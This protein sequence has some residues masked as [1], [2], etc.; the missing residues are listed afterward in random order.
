MRANAC[1]AAIE[2]RDWIDSFNVQHPTRSLVTRIGLHAGE[3]ALGP[4]GGEYHVMGDTPNTAS[5]IQALNKPLATT[6]L[7]SVV[8][9]RDV[10]DLCLRPLGSF[11]LRGKSGQLGVAE[12]MGQGESV[13]RMTRE[14]RRRFAK[15]LQSFKI[16][17][18]SES[19]RLFQDI[20]SDYP[21]DG[22]ARYFREMCERLAGEE[23]SGSS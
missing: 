19:L 14:L 21:S 6:L 23:L 11:A 15:A 18:W 3:I 1:R 10:E 16:G 12:I 17:Y 2:I 7:A 5:R 9:V 22:P 20:L 4:V 8:V 13:D